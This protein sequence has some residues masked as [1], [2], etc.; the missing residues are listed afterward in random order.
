MRKV[1]IGICLLVLFLEISGLIYSR[2]TEEPN[3]SLMALQ[4]AP[5]WI[6]QDPRLNGY[7]LL[8]GFASPTTVNPITSGYDMWID[9]TI[10]PGRKPFNYTRGNRSALFL[11]PDI[12]QT[13]HPIVGQNPIVQIQEDAR[14]LQRHVPQYSHLIS[15]Y[16]RWIDLPFEDRGFAHIGQPRYCEIFAAHRGYLGDGFLQN[17]EAGQRRVKR[18]FLKWRALLQ[19]AKTL[20]LKV[21]AG[22][23][24]S[25]DTAILSDILNQPTITHRSHDTITKLLRPLTQ[26]ERSLRWPIRHEFLVSISRPHISLTPYTPKEDNTT[27]ES[28]AWLTS[29]TD[30]HPDSFKTVETSLSSSFLGMQFQS[31]R[32][33]NIYAIYYQAVIKASETGPGPLPRLTSVARNFSRTLMDT[34]LHPIHQ[35]PTWDHFTDL[36]LSTDARVRLAGLQVML[37]GPSQGRSITTRIAEA[38][39]DYYDPFTGLPLLWNPDQ[40]R[41]YSV[42]KDF[43][44]DGGDVIF[45]ISVPVLSN[46]PGPIA[47]P[48]IPSTGKKH[49]TLTRHQT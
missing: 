11:T 18:D 27:P 25:E 33:K 4:E 47:G 23:M 42:G 10:D 9:T 14:T 48:R 21:F 36:L 43:L 44:D 19:E 37:R 5:E 6:L 13:L 45:D 32:T 41:L 17:H 26:Q 38:G 28:N 31:Q 15:R 2:T 30:L 16:R 39:A 34:L 46:P 24:V 8:L 12:M 22:L 7:F 1:L 35:E 29:M 3:A 20:S 49:F 40:R